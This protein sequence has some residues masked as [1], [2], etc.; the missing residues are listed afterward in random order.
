[1]IACVMPEFSHFNKVQETNKWF[2]ETNICGC[3]LFY[4]NNSY[5]ALLNTKLHRS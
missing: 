5:Y 1:M 4:W 2:K 3:V